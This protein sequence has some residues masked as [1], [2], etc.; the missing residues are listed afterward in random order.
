MATLVVRCARSLHRYFSITG[1]V[2]AQCEMIKIIMLLYLQ[3]NRQTPYILYARFSSELTTHSLTHSLTHSSTHSLT[4]PPTHSST[5][6]PTHSLTHSPT[7]SPTHSLTHPFT[8]PTTDKY[9]R[10][11]KRTKKIKTTLYHVLKGM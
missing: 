1:T 2:L 7:H 5:H 3:S 10:C 8:Q 4:H 9:G 6:S 11:P